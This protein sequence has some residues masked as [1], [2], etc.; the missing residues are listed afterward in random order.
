MFGTDPYLAERS[1]ELTVG[2]VRR[3]VH[4]AG[5]ASFSHSAR[6]FVRR[7]SLILVMLGGRLVRVGLPAYKAGAKSS[8]DQSVSPGGATV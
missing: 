2:A 6:G 4:R 7:L 1:M 8:P 5:L 3:E